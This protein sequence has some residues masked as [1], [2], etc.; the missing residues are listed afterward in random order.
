[1]ASFSVSGN[2]HACCFALRQHRAQSSCSD[3]Q[4][5][6]RLCPLCSHLDTQKSCGIDQGP[7]CGLRPH[8]WESPLEF[9][10]GPYVTGKL[11][12]S[13]LMLCCFRGLLQVQ[14]GH[15]DFV[16]RAHAACEMRKKRKLRCRRAA[17]KPVIGAVY[18]MVQV[19]NLRVAD[20]ADFC[21]RN[22]LS[23]V[24]H[25]V[26]SEPATNSTLFS[27]QRTVLWLR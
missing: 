1:M 16:L 8:Y 7:L 3:R 17:R 5:Q 4:V 20:K 9:S 6:R 26:L 10:F 21:S 22:M 15:C 24:M 27:G 19:S 14:L 23:Y 13:G 11:V 25:S 12:R 2:L 18:S